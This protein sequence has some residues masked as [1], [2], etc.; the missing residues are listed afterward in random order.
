MWKRVANGTLGE[1]RARGRDSVNYSR[2]EQL[3]LV[4]GGAVVLGSLAMALPASAQPEPIEIVGQLLFFA[5]LIAAVF[6]GRRGG[7]LAAI[8][9]S[10]IYVVWRVP[11]TGDPLTPALALV[12]AARLV[13]YGALG[14]AGGEACSR[15][16][17]TLTRLEG[18]SALD[19][20]SHVYNHAYA[21]KTL[22]QSLG[23]FRRYEEPFSVVLLTLA[24]ALFSEVK[25][26][27]QRAL[28]RGV[29][30][31]I[32]ADVRMVDEVA[33]LADGRFLV[34]LPHTATAGATVVGS[35]LETIVRRALGA[36]NQAVTCSTL[37]APEDEPAL[38]ALL[39]DISEVQ[40]SLEE[41]SSEAAST[42]NPA[43][44]STPS[45]R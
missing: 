26:A 21:V 41:Y 45:A 1:H 7:T 17:Y 38:A 19:E 9:A 16:R 44:E 24:P 5:V 34:L 27:R 31:H 30:D 20:W 35:R 23:R 39:A 32:R 18:G 25:P 14:I 4:V 12:I 8:V 22:E 6:Y 13:A 15:L 37:A 33:R 43:P 2:F 10:A 29:A 40:N 3:V 28:I 36:Q 11:L 42:R